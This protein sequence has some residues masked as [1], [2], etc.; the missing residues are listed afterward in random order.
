M[1]SK[2]GKIKKEYLKII[3]QQKTLYFNDRLSSHYKEKIISECIDAQSEF[4]NSNWPGSVLNLVQN[5]DRIHDHQWRSNI[6]WFEFLQNFKCNNS[7]EPQS[8]TTLQVPI[9]VESSSFEQQS[10]VEFIKKHLEHSKDHLVSAMITEFQ[11]AVSLDAL[12]VKQAL[13]EIKHFVLMCLQCLLHYYGSTKKMRSKTGKLYDL[14]VCKVLSGRVMH[15]LANMFKKDSLYCQKLV[16][17]QDISFEELGIEQWFRIPY[18]K[19]ISEFK[20]LVHLDNPLVGV[21][22]ILKT[23]QLICECVDDS[24]RTSLT[25]NGDQVLCIYIYIV[26]KAKIF[27][28]PNYLELILFFVRRSR[29]MGATGYYLTTLENAVSE[30]QQL[31]P[32]NLQNI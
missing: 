29:L 26:L 32:Y 31:H 19:A 14:L 23:T 9:V 11:Y 25:I 16:Q 4:P 15:T 2:A 30:V 7:Q 5:W 18:D 10:L 12:D 21:E 20:N 3:E 27:E 22:C 24:S 17:Y 13:R 8:A 1:G 6:G 28:L